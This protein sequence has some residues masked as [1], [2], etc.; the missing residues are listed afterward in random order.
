VRGQGN[1]RQRTRDYAHRNL[2]NT[3]YSGQIPRHPM[4][5]V[6]RKVLPGFEPCRDPVFS[7]LY[8]LGINRYCSVQTTILDEIVAPNS[9][10]ISARRMPRNWKLRSGSTCA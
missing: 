2:V 7:G 5:G 1:T 6:T 3:R 9:E 10:V 4:E 8:G